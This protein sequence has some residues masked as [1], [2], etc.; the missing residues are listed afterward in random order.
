MSRLHEVSFLVFIFVIQDFKI[1][2][3]LYWD[4]VGVVQH[5]QHLHE[6]NTIQY[7]TEV[8]W[9]IVILT[10]IPNPWLIPYLLLL[11]ELSN[12]TAFWTKCYMRGGR[13]F[14]IIFVYIGTF[15]RMVVGFTTL[16]IITKVV[17]SNPPHGEVYSIQHHVIKFVGD[18]R[19]VGGFLRVLWFA[20]W[21]KLNWWLDLKKIIFTWHFATSLKT[22]VKL[23]L[24]IVYF[25]SVFVVTK[26]CQMFTYTLIFIFH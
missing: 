26:S 17:S 5:K 11:V 23:C 25:Q 18:L 1:F 8:K 9:L 12:Y 19:Q 13:I 22:K 16:P 20:P 10:I 4:T 21:I 24:P 7:I 2:N 14:Q 15:H 6:H 3:Q